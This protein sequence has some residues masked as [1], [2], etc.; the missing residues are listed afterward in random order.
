[1][2]PF[3]EIV[4]VLRLPAHVVKIGAPVGGLAAGSLVTLTAGSPVIEAQIPPSD[5]GLLKVGMSVSVVNELTGLSARGTLTAISHRIITSGSIGGGC[6]GKSTLLNLIGLLDRPTD[7]R[8]EIAGADLT[9]ASEGD[10][11]GV[12]AHQI[13]FVFQSFH[14]LPHRTAA[15]NVMLAQVY[16]GLPRRQRLGIALDTLSRVGLRHRAGALP[17]ELS[18]GER[19]RI[20]VARA[21]VGHPELLLC[22]EP[23]GNL[24]SVTT[25][26]LLGLFDEL[27][28]GGVTLLVI[29]HHE[30]VAERADRQIAIR[31]GRLTELT[32]H[33]HA[34]FST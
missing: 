27:H 30:R 1:M 18:G 34:G 11:T 13:G 10:R 31:D 28:D 33:G 19:Q 15:E 6:S 32:E 23:T 8:I 2:V 4:F 22:D 14:L 5:A 9:D 16:A 21:L 25:S 29:T 24:D 3:D 26:E 17:T 7:G 12:R 20:A